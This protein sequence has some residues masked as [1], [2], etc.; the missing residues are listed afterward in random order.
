MNEKEFKQEEVNVAE[1][2]IIIGDENETVTTFSS[3]N[4]EQ[5][6]TIE[7]NKEVPKKR[8]R[9][10]KKDIAESSAIT[11]EKVNPIDLLNYVDGFDPNS[12]TIE[13]QRDGETIKYL[14]V[15]DRILW[16][17]LKYPNGKIVK[18]VIELNDRFVVIE[19]KVYVDKKDNVDEFL[20][21]ATAQ[22]FYSSTERLGDRYVELAETASVGRALECAGFG[23]QFSLENENIA[24]SKTTIPTIAQSKIPT[25]DKKEVEK[26]TIDKTTESN[27]AS[28]D[29]ESKTEAITLE[30]AYSSILGVGPYSSKTVGWLYDNKPSQFMWFA[31]KYTGNNNELKEAVGFVLKKRGEPVEN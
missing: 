22:R 4:R 10:S 1:V 9:K 30:K 28:K 3:E 8:N 16:F 29:L 11:S 5:T 2:D 6:Q 31:T 26:A 7:D 13:I 19:T 27:E 25:T 21:N 12:K 15:A 14:C 24:K 17:R 23:T 20:S 18:S